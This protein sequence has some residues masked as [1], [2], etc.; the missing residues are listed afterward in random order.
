HP[1]RTVGKHERN[2]VGVRGAK[3]PVIIRTVVAIPSR[4]LIPPAD[5]VP[6]PTIDVAIV[7]IPLPR[8]PITGTVEVPFSD[9]ESIRC[10]VRNIPEGWGA[11]PAVGDDKPVRVER[12][13]PVWKDKSPGPAVARVINGSPQSGR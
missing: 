13:I 8:F 1:H 4:N 6:V 3:A 5:G 10:T 2:A 9:Q 11:G 7:L 12:G